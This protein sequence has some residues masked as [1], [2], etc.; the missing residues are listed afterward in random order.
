M[1]PYRGRHE[2]GTCP[3]RRFVVVPIGCQIIANVNKS[4]KNLIILNST[5]LNIE[6]NTKCIIDD[7]EAGEVG[8]WGGL[9]D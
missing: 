6:I 2:I 3:G 5:K 1:V 4:R 7:G 9:L 8:E